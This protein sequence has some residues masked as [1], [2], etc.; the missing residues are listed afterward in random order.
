MKTQ[1]YVITHKKFKNTNLEGYIPIQVGAFGKEKLGYLDDSI[2]D[3]I[4]DKN[5]NYC[6]LTGIYWLWKNINDVDIIG[7]NHYRRYFSKSE[8]IKSKKLFLTT[9]KIEDI[10]KTY[11]IILQ[12]REVYREIA[13]KQYCNNSGFAEDLEKIREIISQKY[14]NYLQAFDEV[15][16]SNRMYQFNMMICNKSLYNKYCDWLFDILFELEKTVDLSKYNDYQKRI[17]GFLSERLL[18]VWVKT[19][20]LKVKEQRVVNT[21]DTIKDILTTK[22]R[23][24]KNWLIFNIN[25][26]KKQ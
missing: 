9:K 11:D 13:Y 24:A 5:K 16:N 10:L 21:E 7:I 4:S 25:R 6:E 1:L 8:I 2:K 19:N 17:Y 22:L 3:N 23:R 20:N 18:N 26:S 12:K 15:M 14:N